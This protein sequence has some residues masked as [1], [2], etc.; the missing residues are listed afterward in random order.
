MHFLVPVPVVQTRPATAIRFLVPWPEQT[1]PSAPLIHSLV[2]FPVLQTPPP[3]IH[4]LAPWPEQTT[5]PGPVIHFSVI[6][7]AAVTL[8]AGITPSL[9]HQPA[10]L[11]WP[12]PILSLAVRLA[13][14]TLRAE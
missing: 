5:P 6:T 12:P 14:V 10:P 11:T 1:T 8:R 4:F 7:Q 13:R 2:S 3:T 9:A